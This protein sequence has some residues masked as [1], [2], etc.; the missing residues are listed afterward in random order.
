MLTSATASNSVP[1]YHVVFTVG[2]Y[3]QR[4]LEVADVEFTDVLAVPSDRRLGTFTLTL[5]DTNSPLNRHL[6]ETYNTLDYLQR[7]EIYDRPIA[8]L[9]SG[10]FA[11]PGTVSPVFTGIITELPS[12]LGT[13]QVRGVSYLGVLE[14]QRLRRYE[15]HTGNA[16]D[17]MRELLKLYDWDFYDNFN[18]ASIGANWTTVSG[19]WSIVNGALVSSTSPSVIRTTD[20]TYLMD[21]TRI[22][23]DLKLGNASIFYAAIIQIDASNYLE[24]SFSAPYALNPFTRVYVSQTVSGVTSFWQRDT[25]IPESQWMSVDIYQKADADRRLIV[26]INGIEMVDVS[27]TN[28]ASGTSSEVRFST[29]TYSATI[30]CSVDNFVIATKRAKISEGDWDTTSETP[31]LTFNGDNFLDAFNAYAD[32]LNWEYRMNYGDVVGDDTIDAGASVGIDL[33]SAVVLKEGDNLINLQRNRTSDEIATRLNMR[34]ERSDDAANGFI[35]QALSQFPTYGII[36]G[37]YSDS[38]IVDSATA[39]LLGENRLAIISA[40]NVSLSGTLLDESALVGQDPRWG[41]AIWGDAIWGGRAQLRPGDTVWLTS[42]TLNEDRAALIV[43]T[44]RRSGTR[45]VDVVFDYHPWRRADASKLVRWKLNQLVREFTNRLN[46]QTLVFT[47]SGTTAQTIAFNLRGQIVKTYL[48]LSA[49]AW[50]GN[51]TV[52]IDGTDRTS[53]LFGAAT[54]GA[55]ARVTDTQ[56]LVLEG[57]HTITLTPSASVTVTVGISTKIIA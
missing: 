56:Y 37:E 49:N 50:G 3:A 21:D 28:F 23:F 20:T 39:K 5:K 51:V 52:K 19:S 38:R 8:D 57:T 22:S 13:N 35:A 34:G 10:A 15:A 31:E 29:Q 44:T 2:V 14:W 25:A 9:S 41:Y 40:G 11:E 32:S 17:E 46:T 16:A 45:E 1:V 42:E 53:E 6:R 7:I 26:E 4:E 43:S 36:D 54:V 18:R 55:N 47:L 30:D 33:S 24:V 48:D 12:D 27:A